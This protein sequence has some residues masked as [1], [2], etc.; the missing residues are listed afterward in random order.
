[1]LN[2]IVKAVMERV[3]KEMQTKEYEF[4]GGFLVDGDMILFGTLFCI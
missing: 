2:K 3:V 1:M 4:P